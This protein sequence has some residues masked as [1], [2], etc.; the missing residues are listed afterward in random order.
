MTAAL[1]LAMGSAISPTRTIEDVDRDIAA[2]ERLIAEH[3][4]SI[5]VALRKGAD[6]LQA[7]TR[8]GDIRQGLELL[9]AQRRKAVRAAHL[10]SRSISMRA[11]KSALSH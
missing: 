2:T 6:T 1:S 8:L 10:P 11:D 5:M 9:Y 3:V 4:Q 7:E